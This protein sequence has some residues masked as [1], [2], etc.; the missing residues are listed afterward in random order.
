MAI[1]ETKKTE[2]ENKTKKSKKKEELPVKG[3]VLAYD[4]LL[5]PWITEKS[6][7]SVTLNKYFF[8]VT[9]IAN[10]ENLK[11]AIEELYQVKVKSVNIVNIPKKQK[12]RR[13]FKSGFKKAIVT[14]KEGFKIDLFKG[15]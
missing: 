1:I 12:Y 13:G 7:E 10:K 6:H 14:L 9:K 11:N 4:F 15:V 8:K 5:E 2:K 3:S